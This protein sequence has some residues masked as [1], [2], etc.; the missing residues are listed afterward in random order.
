MDFS[1]NKNIADMIGVNEAILL[2]YLCSACRNG[3]LVKRHYDNSSKDSFLNRNF[4]RSSNFRLDKQ[5]LKTGFRYKRISMNVI[6]WHLSWVSVPTARNVITRL[7]RRGLIDVKHVDLIRN[8]NTNCYSVNNVKVAR[9]RRYCADHSTSEPKS[10]R[11]AKFLHGR[12]DFYRS[13]LD[14]LNKFMYRDG[15]PVGVIN[16]Y[17]KPRFMI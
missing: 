3:F 14:P 9:L 5:H 16:D 6:H 10:K 11:P 12:Y 4:T 7:K 13:K 1:F 17:D 2:R 8:D 15:K